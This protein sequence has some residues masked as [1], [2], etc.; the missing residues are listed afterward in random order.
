MPDLRPSCL[1]NKASRALLELVRLTMPGL[2]SHPR[3][4][5]PPFPVEEKGAVLS[6]AGM[7]CPIAHTLLSLLT[8]PSA[9]WKQ[10]PQARVAT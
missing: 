4:L 8:L 3:K 9:F 10:I 2:L 6:I 7:V 1:G 5:L